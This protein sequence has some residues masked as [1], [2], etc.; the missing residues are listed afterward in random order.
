MTKSIKNHR[1][2]YMEIKEFFYINFQIKDG[3]GCNSQ[4]AKA[5]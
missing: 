1:K 2:E 5:S 4:L 3:L